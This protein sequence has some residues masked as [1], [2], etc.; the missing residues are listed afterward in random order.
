MRP[1]LD[2]AW[3]WS[4]LARA[5]FVSDPPATSRAL[6]RPVDP[7]RAREVNDGSRR[8][9]PSTIFV[10]DGRSASDLTSPSI[11][12]ESVDCGRSRWQRT[13]GVHWDERLHQRDAAN[14]LMPGSPRSGASR[15]RARS[16]TI[17]PDWRAQSRQTPRTDRP[18]RRGPSGSG[19]DNVV[20]THPTDA[21]LP[22]D[23]CGR[24][25]SHSAGLPD[26]H[27]FPSGQRT[28]FQDL[29]ARVLR[30][31]ILCARAKLRR[32][33]V[34]LP[35]P[36]VA[37]GGLPRGGLAAI[38]SLPASW[39]HSSEY[40]TLSAGRRNR[41][42]HGMIGM[43]QTRKNC[44]KSQHARWPTMT[45]MPRGIGKAARSRCAPEHQAL[46]RA[47][48]T[49]H[50]HSL[51]WTSGVVQD[52]ISARSRHS[53]IR[54]PAWMGR[55]SWTAIA[56]KNSGC[57]V[58]VQ[59]FL[60]WTCPQSLRRRVRQRGAVPHPGPGVATSPQATARDA[61]A[62][63]CALQLKPAGQRPGGLER[64]PLWR[65]SRLGGLARLHDRCRIRGTLI[66]T[67]ARRVLPHEMQ[68]WLARAFGGKKCVE[69]WQ[70]ATLCSA[71]VEGAPHGMHPPAPDSLPA[72]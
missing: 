42:P 52:A 68:P 63:R 37:G 31:A 45:G 20:P 16:I 33:E 23:D 11:V 48:P 47:H 39:A 41:Q 57:E 69:C 60:N 26:E 62:G 56:R 9:Q 40:A 25:V 71:S 14:C 28:Q 24:Q 6:T 58:L 32:D 15:Y 27:Q 66:T 53:G 61:E 34:V 13:T 67:T 49:C 54:W 59:N 51:C 55:L 5:R 4:I 35:A 65:L 3:A 17:A 19:S 21:R 70:P 8:R 64:G 50:R 29:D 22:I 46:L 72:R 1:Q 36:K 44:I 38:F 43:S 7:S 2:R 10:A 18:R 30:G 12:S